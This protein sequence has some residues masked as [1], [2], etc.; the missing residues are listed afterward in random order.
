M[1]ATALTA[2]QQAQA[3]ANWQRMPQDMRDFATALVAAGLADGRPAS[4]EDG[5]RMLAN[6]RIVTG[7]ER[8]PSGDGVRPCIVTR[9]E[10]EALEAIAR[11]G[12]RK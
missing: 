11:R 6:V 3:K 2:E 4:P 10:R 7:T 8:L 1:T 5:R 9:A 12:T